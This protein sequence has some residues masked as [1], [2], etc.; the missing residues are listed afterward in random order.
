MMTSTKN[1]IEINK[2]NALAAQWWNLDGPMKPLHDI[3][4]ARLAF[5]KQYIDLK[6]QTVMDLGCGAG[7]FSE[8]LAE[9]G[10]EVIGLDAANDVIDAAI[11]H[12][13]ASK[14]NIN[15]QVSPV[16]NFEHAP[17]DAIT[18]MEMLEHV[19]SP[20][21]VL[22]HCHRLIKPDGWLFLSTIN[23]G[24]MS[25]LKAIIG[26]EYILKLLPKQT[27]DYQKFIK[28]SE[29]TQIAKEAGFELVA[30]QGMDYHPFTRKASL[31]SSVSVNYLMA[32]KKKIG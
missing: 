13:K 11:C 23:R 15:Y 9:S 8:A 24:V 1:E 32:L 28:P 27:H 31:S 5:V 19:D 6:G 21:I 22:Q 18:C 20:L 25:Y 4:P 14:L 2:F 10:A 3:N 7:I 12:A 29:L 30:L 26:A 17:L 16:E